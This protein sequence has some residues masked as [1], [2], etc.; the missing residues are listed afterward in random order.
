M[1]TGHPDLFR[2]F[3][4]RFG[5]LLAE[6]SGRYGVVLPGDAF[7]IKGNGPVR[8]DLDR[9]ARRV[10]V[11]ML[12]NRR[13]WVFK[14]V[15]P[16]KL[17]ALVGA[18]IRGV[19]TATCNY[20]FRPEYH[21][22]IQFRARDFKNRVERSSAWLRRYSP[23]LVQPTLPTA[24]A[25]ASL[26]VIDV[27][28]QSP[29]IG[30]HPTL[31]AR[32]VYA[33]VETTRDKG[34]YGAP[35]SG[36]D[37]WPVYGGDSFDIWRP[38]SGTYYALTTQSEALDVVQRK[39]VNSPSTS[40]YG[41]MPR[42]WR[43]DAKT[44]PCLAPRI[45]FRNVTNRTNQRTLLASLVP[46]GRILVQTAPWILWLSPEKPILHEAFLLGVM[47][48]IPADWWMRRFVEGHVDEEAFASL[49]IPDAD[50][51]SGLG[52]GVVALAGR[53]ACPDERFAA[54]AAAVGVACGPL[55]PVD[56]RRMIEKL[57]A[58]VARLYG[59][60]ADHLSHIFDTFH[61]WP[62]TDQAR[63]WAERRDRTLAILRDLS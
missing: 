36:S 21:R 61:E 13:E 20:I 58:V 46:A 59:L 6:Q 40:P 56:K 45:A 50:P 35:E 24:D 11:Q 60:T 29:R 63:A 19:E 43:D 33:D 28:M 62:D 26:S 31:R 17:V 27:M 10:D 32:R 48:S 42:R 15:H 34:I 55:H 44:H 4:A 16:Q 47:S 51:S 37:T 9:R 30:A 39:R 14:D 5:Q 38:D 23:G 52:A 1:N 41:L 2:A 54:W 53:L 12:T 57:D 7:K 3:M 49:R 8:E 22:E 18:E 25:A